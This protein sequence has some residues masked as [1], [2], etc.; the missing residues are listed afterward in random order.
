MIKTY[1]DVAG[2]FGFEPFY[3]TTLVQYLKDG[4]VGAEMG[5]FD[6]KSVIFLANYI[7]THSLNVKFYAVDRWLLDEEYDRFIQNVKD[8]GVVDYLVPIRLTSDKAAETFPDNHFDFVF[9]DGS[10]DYQSVKLD[11]S[12]WYPKVKVGGILGGDDYVE[13]WAEVMK[14]VDDVF[15]DK[16]LK[17]FPAWYVYKT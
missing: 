6:G 15:G 7:K 4:M 14:A 3:S 8:C 1:K 12:Y 5:V 16:A 17:Q 13:C 9:I 2:W 11:I 10:H